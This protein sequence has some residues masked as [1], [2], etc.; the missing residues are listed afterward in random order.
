MLNERSY[1]VRQLVA[2]QNILLGND[3]WIES[4]KDYDSQPAFRETTQ[5]WIAR[6]NGSH[7]AIATGKL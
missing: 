2:V 6:I 5:L 1:K 3:T 4:V 7:F